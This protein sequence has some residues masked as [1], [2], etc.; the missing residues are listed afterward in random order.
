MGDRRLLATEFPPQSERKVCLKSQK[1]SQ[2][3][4]PPGGACS[5]LSSKLSSK[6]GSRLIS[7]LGESLAPSTDVS[8]EECCPRVRNFEERREMKRRLTT[9]QDS[10]GG[11]RTDDGFSLKAVCP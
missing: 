10:W 3:A 11:V 9:L 8:G 6:L 5:P 4:T 7:K 1:W 2:T